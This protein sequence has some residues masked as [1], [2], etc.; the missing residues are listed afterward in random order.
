[1]HVDFFYRTIVKYLI[2][3]LENIVNLASF[4]NSRR[5]YKNTGQSNGE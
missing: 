5:C 3:N 1:M 4:I 2:N